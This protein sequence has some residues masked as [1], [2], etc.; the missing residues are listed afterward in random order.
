METKTITNDGL[1]LSDIAARLQLLEN[2]QP[3]K[4]VNPE[5]TGDVNYYFPTEIP[6]VYTNPS[7]TGDWLDSGSSAHVPGNA[8]RAIIMAWV[9]DSDGG[10]G[11]TTLRARGGGVDRVIAS[12]YETVDTADSSGGG[13]VE[14][15][16]SEGRF[17]WSLGVLGAGATNVNVRIELVGYV[18]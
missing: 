11:R 12:L 2:R 15:P 3:S 10:T 14:V 18:I 6:L 16:V 9:E 1:E 7:S 17:D 13:D 8:K 5:Q 4:T